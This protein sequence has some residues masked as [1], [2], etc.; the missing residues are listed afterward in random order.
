ML[1]LAESP[2]AAEALA[3]EVHA[4]HTYHGTDFDRVDYHVVPIVRTVRWLNGKIE[5]ID[6]ASSWLHDGVEDSRLKLAMLTAMGYAS[7]VV[8]TVGYL[9]IK[10]WGNRRTKPGAHTAG[11]DRAVVAHKTG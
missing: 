7:A 1:S 9:S 10:P 5:P 3:R 2:Q 11:R 4:G 6:E 8:N